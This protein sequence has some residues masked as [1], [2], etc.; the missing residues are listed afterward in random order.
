MGVGNL[1]GREKVL[2]NCFWTISARSVASAGDRGFAPGCVCP[3]AMLNPARLK[4]DTAA[5]TAR[6]LLLCFIIRVY[7]FSSAHSSGIAPSYRAGQHRWEGSLRLQM[8]ERPWTER[9]SAIPGNL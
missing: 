3:R 5:R 1:D 2:P 8:S 6:I 4:S 9:F 7:P